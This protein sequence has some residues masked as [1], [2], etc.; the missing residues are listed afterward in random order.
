VQLQAVEQNPVDRFEKHA[1][2]VVFAD[3][4]GPDAKAARQKQA[5]KKKK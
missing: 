2:V 5:A 1:I 4:S 3:C